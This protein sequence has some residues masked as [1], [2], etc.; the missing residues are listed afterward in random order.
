MDRIEIINCH[1]I[2]S[3][4]QTIVVH[5]EIV[6]LGTEFCTVGGTS[7]NRVLLTLDLM[8]NS[9]ASAGK[10]HGDGR[11]CHQMLHR[12]CIPVSGPQVG[13]GD[14]IAGGVPSINQSCMSSNSCQLPAARTNVVMQQ[15]PIVTTSKVHVNPSPRSSPMPYG[16]I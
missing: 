15:R 6:F 3:L 9:L 7:K 11:H 2:P 4:V 13:H 8:R 5:F 10:V 16:V 12:Y 14:R 1:A